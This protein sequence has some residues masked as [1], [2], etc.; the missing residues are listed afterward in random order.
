M[1]DF[2]NIRDVFCSINIIFD[3]L[4]NINVMKLSY[5]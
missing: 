3:I 1:T 2:I 4:Y 5:V